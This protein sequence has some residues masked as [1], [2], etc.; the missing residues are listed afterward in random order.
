MHGVI[1]LL[2]LA[3]SRLPVVFVLCLRG[4]IEDVSDDVALMA[5]VLNNA[6]FCILYQVGQEL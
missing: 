2:V 4:L 3:F 6:A 1:P 5:N